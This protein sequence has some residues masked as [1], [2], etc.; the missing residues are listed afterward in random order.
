MKE[1]IGIICREIAKGAER[2]SRGKIKSM[3]ILFLKPAHLTKVY[4]IFAQKMVMAESV[5]INI[6]FGK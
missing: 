3:D 6:S 4:F 1:S 2:Y 5:I